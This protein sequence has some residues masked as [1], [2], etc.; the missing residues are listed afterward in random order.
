MSNP[1][2]I[3]AALEEALRALRD[4]AELDPTRPASNS[5]EKVARRS[6]ERISQ[7]IQ[8]DVAAPGRTPRPGENSDYPALRLQDPDY[9]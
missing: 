3:S 5:S 8:R 1:A 2:E 9:Y 6:L 7:L 4:V